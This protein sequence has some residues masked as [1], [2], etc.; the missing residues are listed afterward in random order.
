MAWDWARRLV[1]LDKE[2]GGE[3]SEPAADIGDGAAE[4]QIGWGRR[5]NLSSSGR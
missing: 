3:P 5:G 1:G 4:R 2:A